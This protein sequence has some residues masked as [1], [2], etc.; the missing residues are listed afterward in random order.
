MPS[1]RTVKIAGIECRVVLKTPLYTWQASGELQ[2]QPVVVSGFKTESEAYRAWKTAA[3]QLAQKI[4]ASQ[5]APQSGLA[6]GPT[7]PPGG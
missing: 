6:A 2:G 5:P 7:A 4:A 1:L 3:S